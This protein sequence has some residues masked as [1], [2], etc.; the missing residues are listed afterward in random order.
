MAD[1]PSADVHI[2]LTPRHRVCVIAV[3]FS[4]CGAVCE[5]LISYAFVCFSG[6]LLKGLKRHLRKVCIGDNVGMHV[7]LVTNKQ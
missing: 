1:S 7:S 2:D 5:Y 6:Q 3:K 4:V